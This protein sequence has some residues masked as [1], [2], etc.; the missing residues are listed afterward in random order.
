MTGRIVGFGANNYGQLGLGSSLSFASIQPPTEIP[1]ARAFPKTSRLQGALYSSQFGNDVECSCRRIFICF[2][3]LR[4]LKPVVIFPI[5]SSRMRI[6][7]T[8]ARQ[9]LF[10]PLEMVNLGELE[11]RN[12]LTQVSLARLRILSRI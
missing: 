1:I 8:V 5:L 4:E 7:R 9:F 12:G 10:S 11:I 3:Q 6:F 2:I